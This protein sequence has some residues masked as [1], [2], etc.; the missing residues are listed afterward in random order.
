MN[1]KLESFLSLLIV[2]IILIIGCVWISDI[3][4]SPERSF[5]DCRIFLDEEECF[6]EASLK[7]R[8]RLFRSKLKKSTSSLHVYIIWKGDFEN[9]AGPYD[10]FGG[11]YTIYF[12]KEYIEIF[13]T[14]YLIYSSGKLIQCNFDE[15]TSQ[16]RSDFLEK[17]C[18]AN[19]PSALVTYL[20]YP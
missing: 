1:K 4:K 5:E 12:G 9:Y 10:S 18:V 17:F 15:G 6:K 3:V 20:S 11:I 2:A 14:K 13:L 8:P 7:Q 19:A 16:M